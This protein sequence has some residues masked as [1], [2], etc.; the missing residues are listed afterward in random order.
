MT[1]RRAR[2]YVPHLARFSFKPT[3][4]WTTEEASELYAARRPVSSNIQ[5]D[6]VF[7]EDCIS[8]MARLPDECVDLVVADPPFGID[9]DGK[10]G[11]YNRDSGYVLGG[12]EEIQGSYDDFTY[13]WIHEIPRILKPDGSAYVFS[14]WTNLEAVLRAGRETGL[15]LLNHVIW[16][17]PFGVYTRKRLVTS[18]YHI[19][20]FVK[21]S[22]GYFF[23]KFEH[24]PEDVWRI[25]RPYRIG[26]AKNGTRL[27]LTVVCRCI[28]FSSMPGDIVLDPFMGNGTTAVAAKSNWRHFIGFEIN[29]QLKPIIGNELQNIR[30][31]ESY[32]PYGG[33]LPT[34]EELARMYPK[35]HKEFLR[36]PNG[37]GQSSTRVAD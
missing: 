34:T 36:G 23:N 11:A 35:A 6:H 31:G 17:Y 1:G 26:Q 12:Y 28:D 3:Y 14:G 33:R 10:S 30:P 4:D 22:R 18:H 9:F 25:K 20:L 7:F 24:Y 37:D 8:G 16:H 19:L 29:E 21:D 2:R 15:S 13:K 32:R 5:L 27:P